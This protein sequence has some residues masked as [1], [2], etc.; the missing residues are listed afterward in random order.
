MESYRYDQLQ[1]SDNDMEVVLC[2][3][4]HRKRRVAVEMGVIFDED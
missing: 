1:L 3:M 2:V 4:L